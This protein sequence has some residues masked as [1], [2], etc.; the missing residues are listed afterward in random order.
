MSRTS[1]KNFTKRVTTAK[2][3]RAA[4]YV[5]LSVVKLGQQQDSI[6]NQKRMIEEFIFKR[7]DMVLNR[8]FVDENASGSSFERDAFQ[9]LLDAVDAGQIDCI[10]VKDA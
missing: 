8:F 7:E 4:G 1:R 9:E 5:R 2:I 3:Y 6:E 10:I